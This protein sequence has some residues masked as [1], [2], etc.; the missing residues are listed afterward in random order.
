M[1]R[2]LRVCNP[3]FLS[4]LAAFLSVM[5]L[6]PSVLVWGGREGRDLGL[7]PLVVG[8]TE[9]LTARVGGLTKLPPPHLPRL[10]CRL[11]WMPSGKNMKTAGLC[12][13]ELPFSQAHSALSTV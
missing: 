6:G 4:A 9:S 8:T 3:R 13:T 2:D 7:C 11:K 1:D 10:L 5:E 12:I